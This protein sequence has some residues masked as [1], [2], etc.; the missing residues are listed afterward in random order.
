MDR[1]TDSRGNQLP[2]SPAPLQQKSRKPQRGRRWRRLRRDVVRIAPRA[3]RWLGRTANAAPRW[4]KLGCIAV[5][6]LGTF[7]LVN[8]AYHVVR[9]PTELFVVTGHS[10]DKEPDETWRQ[11]GALFREHAT[12]A[13]TAELLAALAQTESSGNPVARTYWRWR[14]A[15]NPF[16][17]YQPA[18]SAVGLFQMTDGAFADAS[19]FCIRDHEVVSDGCGSPS[20]YV[21]AWPA[22][23]VALTVISL[24]RQVASVLARH[25]AAKPT[26]QQRQDLA[27]VIHLC[28][29]GPGAGFARRGFKPDDGERCGDH[30][31]AGYLRKVNAMKKQFQKLAASERS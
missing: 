27:A 11:Y 2:N 23:A 26:A 5:L 1:H 20:L 13:I 22:H 3:A 14:L 28:G 8:L 6:A 12:R 21:R 18:S 9:K 10:L 24:D 15:W 16:A 25:P 17:L 29:S 31:V 30:S 7:A 19:R 4:L